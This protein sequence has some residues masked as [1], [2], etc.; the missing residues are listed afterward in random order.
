MRPYLKVSNKVQKES[1]S[2]FQMLEYQPN[3][4]SQIWIQSDHSLQVIEPAMGDK[5]KA[6]KTSIV[7]WWSNNLRLK[8]QPVQLRSKVII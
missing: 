3:F 8:R 6:V 5:G 4:P 1:S 2:E 7:V